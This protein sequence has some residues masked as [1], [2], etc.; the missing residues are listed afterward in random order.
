MLFDFF[1][2]YMEH[3]FVV[4]SFDIDYLKELACSRICHAPDQLALLLI[5]KVSAW[6]TT[7]RRLDS[8]RKTINR[9]QPSREGGRK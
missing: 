9:Q 2:Q 5:M 3:I 7:V 6:D 1:G 8:G 4:K